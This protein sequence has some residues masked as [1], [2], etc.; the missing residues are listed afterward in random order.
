VRRMWLRGLEKVFLGMV[1]ALGLGW[2]QNRI[3]VWTHF[4]GA[5]LEWLKQQASAYQKAKGVQ[6]LI[7]EMPLGD[8]HNKIL[9]SAPQGHAGD[10]FL[11]VPHDWI[12]EFAQAGVLEPLDR[13][14][15]SAYRA[16]VEPVALEAFSFRGRL[17]GFPAYAESVALIYNKKFVK[18]APK[19]W[20]EF[21]ALAQRY[22]TKETFGFLYNVNEGYF[23]FGFYRAYGVENVF[24]KDASGSYDPRR[25]LL[26]G[27]VGERVLQLLKD[28]RFRYRLIP[29]GTNYEVA[30]GAFKSGSLAM[31]LNGPWALGDYKKA[32]IDFGIAPLPSPPGAVRPWGPFLGVHGIGV[33][34]FSPRKALALDFARFLVSQDN[35]VAF[36]QAGG[37]TPVSKS[38]V[39]R[40]EKDPVVAGFAKIFPLGVPMPNIPEMGKV[41]A[42]WNNAIQLAIQRPDSDVKGIVNNLMVELQK[43][44]GR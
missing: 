13:Y 9:L 32:G 19:S 30:D 26:G 20:A 7:S 4:Q 21:L 3:E 35:L 42:P 27:A 33:N 11:T 41:W 36:N 14:V 17:F 39:K 24:A 18:G 2:A 6:V 10:L 37:R 15:D 22:T 31:I 40:L 5:E 29:E 8:M 1:V 43:A 12:G 44:L 28:L 25:I 16:D 38:A 23:N 34:A